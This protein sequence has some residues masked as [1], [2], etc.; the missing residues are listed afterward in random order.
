MLPESEVLE[1]AKL[2]ETFSRFTMDTLIEAPE[3]FKIEYFRNPAVK[4]HTFVV[5][6]TVTAT[7]TGQTWNKRGEIKKKW[8]FLPRYT[9][10]EIPLDDLDFPDEGDVVVDAEILP[11]R[12]EFTTDADVLY[13]TTEETELGI[14]MPIVVTGPTLPLSSQD[15]EAVAPGDV[16][17][18]SID[19]ENEGEDSGTVLVTLTAIDPHGRPHF[20]DASGHQTVSLAPGESE[21]VTLSWTPDVEVREGEYDLRAEVWLETD[22]EDRVALL[23]EHTEE[24]VVTVEKPDGELAVTTIPPDASVVLDGELLEERS[25]ERPV[26]SYE[27]TAFHEEFGTETE[28]VTIKEGKTTWVELDLVGDDPWIGDYTNARWIVTEGGLKRAERDWSRD[29]IDED[30]YRAV[31]RAYERGEQLYEHRTPGDNRSN[32]RSQGRD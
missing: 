13:E 28:S 6:A 29:E 12:S 24:N 15:Q 20:D 31:E 5:E 1:F 25:I 9:T 23:D 2:S 7:E 11:Y 8:T 16:V 10:I 30:L 19:L 14:S 4:P 17:E 3:S 18:R 22:L 27:V 26:G 32:G 21:E